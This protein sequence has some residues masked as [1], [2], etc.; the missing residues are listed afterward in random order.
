MC[1]LP[2]RRDRSKHPNKLEQDLGSPVQISNEMD[3]ERSDRFTMY[4]PN[5]G[6]ADL[7]GPR[8]HTN[9]IMTRLGIS[10]L[11]E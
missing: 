8:I 3:N 9:K 1:P 10:Y 2:V 7:A 4:G 5:T 6:R 11:R